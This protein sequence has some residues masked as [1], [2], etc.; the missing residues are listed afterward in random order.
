MALDN[1]NAIVRL[2]SPYNSLKLLL[3]AAY[4]SRPPLRPLCRILLKPFMRDG[5]VLVNYNCHGRAMQSYVRLSDLSSDFLSLMELG[6]GDTYDLDEGLKPGLVI[7]GGGN[8]GLSP[9][10]PPQCWPRTAFPRAQS[11]SSRCRAMSSRF[12]STST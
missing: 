6:A 4:H 5:E 7:D 8:I 10:E 2:G 12:G 1:V 3:V 9:S 11:S